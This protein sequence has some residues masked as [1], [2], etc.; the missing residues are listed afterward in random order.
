VIQRQVR[1]DRVQLRAHARDGEVGLEVPVVVPA[2]R[3][4]PVAVLDA[5]RREGAGDL[6]DAVAVLGVGVAPVA[7]VRSRND[8]PVPEQPLGTPQKRL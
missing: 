5:G 2:Q 1:V 4:D 8:F 3:P 7:T 6:P